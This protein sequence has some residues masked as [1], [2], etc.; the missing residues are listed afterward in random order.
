MFYFNNRDMIIEIE[1]MNYFQCK[2]DSFVYDV[3]EY[4]LD[5][6]WDML[7]GC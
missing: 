3:I 1:L 5:I 6:S 7:F 2:V 4:R